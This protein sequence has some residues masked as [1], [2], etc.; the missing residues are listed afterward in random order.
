MFSCGSVRL[1]S[2]LRSSVICVASSVRRRSAFSVCSAPRPASPTEV[3]LKSRST[4]DVSCPRCT[5][6]A[7]EIRVRPR[8]STRSCFKW[9]T[10]C[11]PRSSVWLPAKLSHL[12]C[13]HELS[14]TSN[15]AP[16]IA[17]S[18]KFRSRSSRSAEVGRN[19][20]SEMPVRLR[21][22]I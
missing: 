15:V 5:P 4:K 10:F 16:V 6:A 7:S 14:N 21:F 8:N 2:A 1:S 17:V 22:S 20:A 9:L 3:W 13:G 12:R 11:M 19:V 18:L